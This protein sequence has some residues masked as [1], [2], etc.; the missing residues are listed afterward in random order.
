[1]TFSLTHTQIIPDAPGTLLI[2]C[3][4]IAMVIIKW[5]FFGI[6]LPEVCVSSGQEYYASFCND[7]LSE[8]LKIVKVFDSFSLSP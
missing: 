5:G 3:Q 2:F 4:L 7:T 1:M 8:L 6:V